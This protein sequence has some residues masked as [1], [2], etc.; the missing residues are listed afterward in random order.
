MKYNFNLKKPLAFFDLETTGVDVGRDRIVELAIVKVMPNGQVH[1]MPAEGQ[2]RLVFNP[3]IPIPIESSLIHG[4]YP[5]DVRNAPTFREFAPKL[6]QLL[7]DCDL[8]GFNSNKFD[9]PLLAE[10]FLRAGIDFDVE[11][12][13]LIDVQVLFHLM[14]PRNLSAALKFYTG[15][16]LEDAHEAMPDV[17]ATADVLNAMIE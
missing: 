2:N 12:R 13:N 17:V 1:K 4:I 8:A 6:Y 5:E 14:E 10:E 7:F 3:E 15:K 9:L 11:G 16:T